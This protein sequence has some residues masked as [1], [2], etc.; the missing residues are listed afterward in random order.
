MKKKEGEEAPLQIVPVRRGIQGR[1]RD[2][3]NFLLTPEEE[4]EKE[5]K[6]PLL[7]NDWTP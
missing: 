1:G 5:L 7:S 4:K 2:H 6:L 3:L